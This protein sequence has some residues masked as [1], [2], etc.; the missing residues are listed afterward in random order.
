VHPFGQKF[1][2][3]WSYFAKQYNL[4]DMFLKSEAARQI[5][6]TVYR[7]VKFL[8]F[9]V[10]LDQILYI[11][12]EKLSASA[13]LASSWGTQTSIVCKW[14]CCFCCTRCLKKIQIQCSYGF[15]VRRQIWVFL[16]GG[17]MRTLLRS[18]FRCIQS[19]ATEVTP[20]VH[21]CPNFARLLLLSLL[22]MCGMLGGRRAA[23]TKIR[24]YCAEWA[25]RPRTRGR[26][27]K[28]WLR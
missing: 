16:F 11:F 17:E 5:K 9:L 27:A 24:V 6:C 28:P 15:I 4:R 13:W 10:R 22:F 26:T 20:L 25:G 23:A 19:E 7:S 1:G 8:K 14:R 12:F 3:N 18:Q 21:G 2:I